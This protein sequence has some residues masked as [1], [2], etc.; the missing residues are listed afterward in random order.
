MQL[1]LL[2]DTVVA[3]VDVAVVV[4][5]VGVVVHATVNAAAV[6]IVDDVATK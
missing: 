4:L 2:I 1:L 5:G 3:A 6:A